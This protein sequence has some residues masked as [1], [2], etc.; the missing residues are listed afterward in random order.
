M[1][2]PTENKYIYGF[3]RGIVI[4]NDDP[5][6]RGRVKIFLPAYPALILNGS[7]TE[8]CELGKVK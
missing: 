5:M 2:I 7:Y 6:D 8:V 4:K 3:T 1:S